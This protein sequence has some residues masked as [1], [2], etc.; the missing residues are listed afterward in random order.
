MK[1]KVLI[2]VIG[3]GALVA[4]RALSAFIKGRAEQ[5]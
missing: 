3:I 1:T 4:M 2:A 5:T